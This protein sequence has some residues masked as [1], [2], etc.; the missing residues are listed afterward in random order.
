MTKEQVDSGPGEL[1]ISRKQ[2]NELERFPSRLQEIE[3]ELKSCADEFT[4]LI[5]R[6]YFNRENG[7]LEEQRKNLGETAVLQERIE[8]LARDLAGGAGELKAFLQGLQKAELPEPVEKPAPP[9]SGEKKSDSTAANG[10]PVGMASGAA[11]GPRP[12]PLILRGGD[13]LIDASTKGGEVSVRLLFEELKIL[14]PQHRELLRQI[15]L[16]LQELLYSHKLVGYSKS[17][18]VFGRE[19]S[20]GQVLEALQPIFLS[21][22]IRHLLEENGLAGPGQEIR[23]ACDQ[24]RELVFQVTA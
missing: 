20:L 22:S 17:A 1:L 4:G 10:G 13:G 14:Q 12:S 11:E 6:H 23:L 9:P 15:S 5:E 2:L 18:L 16:Q 3:Q 24:N 8:K 19:T 7:F 21:E